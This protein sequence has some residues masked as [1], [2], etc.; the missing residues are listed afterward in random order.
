[1]KHIKLFENNSQKYF[2]YTIQ[3]SDEDTVKVKL[4]DS[5][6]SCIKYTITFIHEYDKSHNENYDCK[7]MIDYDEVLDYWNGKY[8]NEPVDFNYEEY[9]VEKFELS[10]E[11]ELL[12]S[13]SKFNL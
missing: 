6:E 12:K 4:F 13:G 10:E 1:M 3:N 7:D 8:Y 11:L 5:A 9:E 2:V